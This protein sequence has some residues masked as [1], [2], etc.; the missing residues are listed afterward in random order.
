MGGAAG[1]E[2]RV[3][4]CGGGGGGGGWGG[5]GVWEAHFW[6]VG[7]WIGCG[8][9]RGWALL[10]CQIPLREEGLRIAKARRLGKDCEG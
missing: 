7:W 5:G 9:A 3:S 8:L 1:G 6:L 2:L 4:C 10:R